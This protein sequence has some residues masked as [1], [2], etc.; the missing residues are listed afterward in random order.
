MNKTFEHLTTIVLLLILTSCM[1]APDMVP[2]MVEGL[3]YGSTLWVCN[4]ALT[5]Q[6]G[7]F[8]MAHGEQTMLAAWMPDARQIGFVL[9]DGG[10]TRAVHSAIQAGGNVTSYATFKAF[11]QA[12]ETD[13]WQFIKP[14]DAPTAVL[15]SVDAAMV[16]L[17]QAASWLVNTPISIIVIP[18]GVEAL[19]EFMRQEMH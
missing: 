2:G 7:S 4:E 9:L 16:A 1:P 19:P 17:T 14:A 6:I 18:A 15:V 10:R 11:K 5:G 8:L 13:G 12:M 3:Q